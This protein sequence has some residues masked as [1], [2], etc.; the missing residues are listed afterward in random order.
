MPNWIIQYVYNTKDGKPGIA[1]RHV[2]AASE[3][4]AKAL[5][6]NLA[7]AEEFVITVHPESD[8]QFL[9]TVKH[10][11]MWLTGKGAE[12]FE[13]RTEEDARAMLLRLL[14]Q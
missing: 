9:G 10:K 1:L 7:P 6:V 11:A 14:G 2:T 5:A 4:D 13:E 12:E 3:T 8:D